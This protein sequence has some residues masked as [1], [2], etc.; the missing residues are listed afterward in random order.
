[1]VITTYQVV[2]SDFPAIEKGRKKK[3]SANESDF[4]VQSEASS[5]SN[6]KRRN[7]IYGIDDD[8]ASAASSPGSSAA[9]NSGL[10]EGYSSG[11]LT[12]N[13]YGPLFQTRWYR[14]VLG[15]LDSLN[16]MHT[17]NMSINA[18]AQMRLNKLK[19]EILVHHYH[20]PVL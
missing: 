10:P 13:G 14:I 4:E 18:P 2:A 8:Q 3:A 9:D 19:T 5:Q 15:K 6:K 11:L 12:T 20:V 17:E 16:N 7:E 1:M